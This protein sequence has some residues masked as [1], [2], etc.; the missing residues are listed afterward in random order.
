MLSELP[1]KDMLV[2]SVL[3]LVFLYIAIYNQ[4]FATY[5]MP[6]PIT[7]QIGSYQLPSIYYGYTIIVLYLLL[8]L[9]IGFY[10]LRFLCRLLD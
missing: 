10:I 3:V 2:I 7:K 9:L 5:L 1:F 4:Y 8:V 6:L